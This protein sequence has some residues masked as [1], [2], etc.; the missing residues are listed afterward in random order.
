KSYADNK[1]STNGTI[2]PTAAIPYPNTFR[3]TYNVNKLDFLV[4]GDWGYQGNGSGQRSVADAMKNWAKQNNSQFIINVGDNFYQVDDND[5]DGVLSVDDPKF[6]SYWLDIYTEKLADIPWY[7]IAGNHDWYTNV[8]ALVDYYWST[9]KRF[10]IPSLY[11][12]RISTFGKRNTKV[13][14]IHIDTDPFAYYYD[15]LTDRNDLKANLATM[16]VKTSDQLEDRLNWIEGQLK[17]VKDIKWIFVVGHHGL[18]G[19][20]SF[21]Y[22]LP[23]LR[24][25]FDKYRVTAYFAGHN[26]VLEME[27]ANKTSHV[28]YFTSGAG[29]K[30]DLEG[31]KG[32]TWGSPG[33]TMG[34]LHVSIEEDS[35]QMYYEYV[36]ATT[37]GQTPKVVK[38]G[39][40]DVR[41][42]N[43][44]S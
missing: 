29:G 33:G 37:A 15:N 22:Y 13:A 28:T 3:E 17:T 23:R 25:L 20:C 42:D 40:I 31:C 2:N 39:F 9:D 35:D 21:P 1:T 43:A 16:N 10:F 8:S 44:N 38:Q 7:T 24:S 34:F 5:Y 41:K 14:W 30:F 27:T 11:Y 12:V 6:K 26:H 19:E 4:I 18:V 32:A 36:N